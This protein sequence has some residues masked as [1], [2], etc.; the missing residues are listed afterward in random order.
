MSDNT[1][2]PPVEE[3][4]EN[5]M[6]GT[7]SASHSLADYEDLSGEFLPFS[8]TTSIATQVPPED[9]EQ[10]LRALSPMPEVETD[11]E[12]SEEPPQKL[13]EL[14]QKLEEPPEKLEDSEEELVEAVGMASI[15]VLGGILLAGIG[16]YLNRP[17]MMEHPFSRLD[18]F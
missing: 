10:L 7:P 2:E 16:L 18:Y 6:D 15:V 9:S 8:R 3:L 11:S 12:D 14:P 5:T 17:L 4:N 13:E 1:V